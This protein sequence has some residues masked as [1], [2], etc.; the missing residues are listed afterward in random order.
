MHCVDGR[1]TGNVLRLWNWLW[2]SLVA[3]NFSNSRSQSYTHYC[4]F[5]PA[6]LKQQSSSSRSLLCTHSFTIE[7]ADSFLSGLIQLW[8]SISEEDSYYVCSFCLLGKDH[9]IMSPYIRMIFFP[10]TTHPCGRQLK[11]GAIDCE[12]HVNKNWT[13]RQYILTIIQS[14]KHVAYT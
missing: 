2:Y 11:D 5:A 4:G 7:Q 13:C 1:T 14:I 3:P 12:M 9:K 8:F 10:C 6:N